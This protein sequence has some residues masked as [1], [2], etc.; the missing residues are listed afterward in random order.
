MLT[1]LPGSLPRCRGAAEVSDHLACT[2][3]LHFPKRSLLDA[4]TTSAS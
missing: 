3:T 1:D 2:E 4:T